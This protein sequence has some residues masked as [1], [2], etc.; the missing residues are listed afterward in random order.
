MKVWIGYIGCLVFIVGNVLSYVFSEALHYK[1]GFCN[2]FY[3][4]SICAGVALISLYATGH[5]KLVDYM[6]KGIIVYCVYSILIFSIDSW[7]P[8]WIFLMIGG[9]CI[10]LIISVLSIRH[11]RFTG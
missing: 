3:F 7:N 5:N 8:R 6:L 9:L 1:E 11:L 2:D 4:Y 10:C